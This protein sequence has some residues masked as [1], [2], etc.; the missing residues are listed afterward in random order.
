[1]GPGPVLDTLTL[2]LFPFSHLEVSEMDEDLSEALFWVCECSP[3]QL[4][5]DILTKPGTFCL[6][7]NFEHQKITTKQAETINIHD[8]YVDETVLIKPKKHLTISIFSLFVRKLRKMKHI[9][10]YLHL[11]QSYQS[12]NTLSWQP[13]LWFLLT[14]C[15]ERFE[16]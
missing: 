12:N 15:A 16:T 6:F 2:N 9:W 8:Q 14:S 11:G 13:K 10:I 4:R 1:M 3:E 5:F 7:Q